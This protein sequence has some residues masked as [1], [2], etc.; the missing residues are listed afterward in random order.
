MTK[1]RI[2]SLLMSVGAVLKADV[3]YH[4]PPHQRNFAWTLEEVR[5]M[6]DD[7]SSAL[8][9]KQQDYFLGTIVVQGDDESKIRTVI[10]GQQRLATLTM[11]FSAIRAIFEEEGNKRAE[12]FK[13]YLGTT[14]V[15]TMR[16]QARLTLNEN[17][18]A[19]FQKL[20]VDLCS[21][22][23]VLQNERD[24]LKSKSNHNL[25]EAVQ[26][27]RAKVRELAD[28]ESAHETLFDLN[29]FVSDRVRIIRVTVSDEADAYLIFETLNDRGLDLTMSD[30]LK[31]Y[32][33]GRA[34]D[35]LTTVKKQWGDVEVR[36]EEE[37][38]TQFL[39]HYWLSKYGVVRERDLYKAMKEKFSTQS[40]VLNLMGDL[41]EA[42]DKYAAISNVDHP[43][44]KG[45]G[46]ALRKD[47]E[48]LQLFGL[49]QFRPLMLAGLSS[50]DRKSLPRLVRLIVVLSM[51]FSIAGSL[52][53]GNIERAYSNA[54]LAVR[55][56]S[57]VTAD[58]IFDKLRSDYPEDERFESDFSVLSIAKSKLAR[59]VMRSLVDEAVNEDESSVNLEHI[60][61][62]KQN[63]DWSEAA[64]DDEEYKAHIH[65]LGNLTLIEASANS[66]LGNASFLEKKSAFSQ[67]EISM[68]RDLCKNPSWTTSD[69]HER[70]VK[71]A[72]K[73]KQV[74]AWPPS[75]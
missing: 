25:A 15:R 30:L 6:W 26:F 38:V 20:V 66:G 52:G 10:D 45:L 43:L 60:M 16:T 58:Q 28:S 46:T 53:T 57:A 32:I 21:D 40:E 44:W 56:F 31:N 33:F 29:D 51:R 71:L 63:A 19:D 5:Q 74:W 9:D 13:D 55:D 2:D 34:G 3:R 7:I 18:K 42:A 73:A 39:R 11:I 35:E 14:D 75:K 24:K 50:L 37:N 36:L 64:R 41:G 22:E 70:Q 72:K 67:S 49:S 23:D 8:A 17:N 48:A 27:I 47:L 62:K 4:V 69:I 61:P 65:R 59:Y 68:T 1:K 12:H 54:A